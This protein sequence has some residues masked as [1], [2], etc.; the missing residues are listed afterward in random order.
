MASTLDA[1]NIL[2][3]LEAR[4]PNARASSLS[5]DAENLVVH[6]DPVTS[7][8]TVIRTPPF[9]SAH[10]TTSTA[11]DNS[12]PFAKMVEGARKLWCSTCGHPMRSAA[13]FCT[14]CG[15]ERQPPTSPSSD[16]LADEVTKLQA[17]LGERQHQ[18]AAERA[19]LQL[20]HA[21]A[22]VAAQGDTR[23][24]QDAADAALQALSNERAAATEFT[25]K[26]MVDVEQLHRMHAAELQ[27]LSQLLR[28]A[29]DAHTAGQLELRA[30]QQQLDLQRDTDSTSRRA[31]AKMAKLVQECHN[32]MAYSFPPRDKVELSFLDATIALAAFK[33]KTCLT[34]KRLRR[35]SLRAKA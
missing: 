32:T 30:L 1:K 9:V 27:Q 35:N 31:R 33:E 29:E 15:G 2:N 16:A 22:I 11:L 19:A 4:Y 12:S 13:D 8:A 18:E 21:E 10:L 14:L 7:V 25:N 24:A 6:I 20:E 5:S 3:E 17:M 23:H 28:V 26:S 34:W